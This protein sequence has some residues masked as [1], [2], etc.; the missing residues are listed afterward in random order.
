MVKY[1]QK[2]KWNQSLFNSPN[3]WLALFNLCTYVASDLAKKKLHI[4]H[5]LVTKRKVYFGLLSDI[6]VFLLQPKI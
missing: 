3:S 4:V 2:Y 6:A 1:L 5:T